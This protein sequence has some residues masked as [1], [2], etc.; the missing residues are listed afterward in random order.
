MP[1]VLPQA[2]LF[3]C[4]FNR[5][6]SPMAAGLMRRLYG[7]QVRVNSCGLHA[8]EEIDPLAAEVMAEIG[9]D[10]AA[11]RPKRLEDILEENQFSQIVALSEEA[12][13]RV[14]STIQN[15]A[16]KWPIAD[17]ADS[18]GSRESRLEAYRLTRQALQ[19]RI[20]EHFG[21]RHTDP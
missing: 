1:K 14:E 21:P 7:D 16:V 20:L 9:V 10:L 4:T 12:W 13:R 18:E 6:R 8:G 19:K 5:V 3:V 15:T 11:H 2:I 17:P